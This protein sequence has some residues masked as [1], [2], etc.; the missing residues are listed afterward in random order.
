MARTNAENQKAFRDRRRERA[1][2]QQEKV[3]K[4]IDT[5]PPEYAADCKMW[6]SPPR[7]G[8]ERPQIHWDIGA[9]THGLIEAHAVA[10]EVTIDEVLYEIGVQYFIGRPKLYWAMKHAKINV[11]DN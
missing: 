4:A 9:L 10:H 2:K 8:G 6:V 5:M 7:I 3:Q 1:T 11:S